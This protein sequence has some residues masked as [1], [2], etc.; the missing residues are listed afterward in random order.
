MRIMRR[1]ESV[2]WHQWVA[3]LRRDAYNRPISGFEADQALEGALF[4]PGGSRESGALRTSYRVTTKP[5]IF[6]DQNPGVGEHD[7]FTVRG[8]RY[9]VDGEPDDWKTGMTAWDPGVEVR[10]KKVSG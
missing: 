10:L 4:A 6:L 9:K 2:I 1:G 5:A 7:E 8:K 3:E